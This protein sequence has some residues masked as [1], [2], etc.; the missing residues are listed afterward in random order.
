LP[1]SIYKYLY[2]YF[3][4]SFFHLYNAELVKNLILSILAI[5]ACALV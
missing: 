1:E 4:S 5:P 3:F 2:K